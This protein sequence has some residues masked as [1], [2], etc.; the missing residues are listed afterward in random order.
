MQFLSSCR[1]PAMQ[2][3]LMLAALA[4]FSPGLAQAQSVVSGQVV[5]AANLRPLPG[6]QVAVQG[7]NRGTLTDGN[8]RFRV[9]V[10]QASVTLNVTF[11]G[12]RSETVSAT[13]G[14][15]V[16]VQLS[17]QAVALD[18]IVVTGT[19]GGTQRRALGHDVARVSATEIREVSPRVD[20]QGVL[21]GGSTGVYVSTSTGN[22][23]G[24]EQ[25]RLRGLSSISLNSV[26]LIYVD[27]VRVSN[28]RGGSTGSTRDVQ[29]SL[30]LNDISPDEIESI[31]VIKGPSAATLYGTEASA[32]VI[33]IITKRGSSGAPVF[34]AGVEY[35]ANY[36]RDPEGR[37]DWNYQINPTTRELTRWHPVLSDPNHAF[38]NGPI[39]NY[40]LGVGGGTDRIKYHLSG[41]GGSEEGYVDW[42][43][44]TRGNLR[45]NLDA[46]LSD[47]LN[48]AFS[49]GV[50]RSN[51][52]FPMPMLPYGYTGS[53]HWG[54]ALRT[55][56]DGHYTL[57]PSD[58]RKI[59][60]RS[61][62]ARSM[63]SL[64]LNH[65][66][67][68]WLR[69]RLTFGE[70]R[71]H[72]IADLLIERQPEGAQH[73][74]F[75]GLGLGQKT[76]E[77]EEGIY[78]SA[79]YSASASFDVTP[80]LAGSTS[81][82]FQH[83]RN[84][85][86]REYLFGREFAAPGLTVLDAASQS[87]ARG[88]FLESASVGMYVQQELSWQNRIFVTGAVRLDDNSA[89]GSEFDAAIY[90]KLSFSWVMHEEEWWRLNFLE[91]FRLRGAWGQAG[92]QPDL[93]AGVS[94]YDPVT[95]PGGSPAVRPG[96]V[97]NSTLGPEV[98]DE[99]EV[100]F[101]AGALND[102]LSVTFNF[103]N[104]RTIDALMLVPI[105]M[106]TGFTSNRWENIGE[107]SNRGIELQVNAGL[108]ESRSLNWDMGVS[109]T[110]NR[111]RLVDLGGVAPSS[112]TARLVEGEPIRVFYSAKPSG[113]EWVGHP[114]PAQGGRPANV[115]CE[116]A[117][118]TTEDCTA[119]Y[120]PSRHAVSYGKNSDPTYFGAVNSSLT[121]FNNL[122]LFAQANYEGGHINWGCRIGCSFGFFR[123]VQGITG[124]PN[125]GIAP[126]PQIYWAGQWLG[127]SDWPSNYDAT[128]VRLQTLSATYT[129]PSSITSRMGV[130]NA[131]LQVAGNN[132]ALWMKQTETGTR[133][134]V[135]PVASQLS[136][137]EGG[138]AGAFGFYPGSKIVTS[139]RLRF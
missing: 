102:R 110:T 89:F 58:E 94:L 8:G 77:V 125:N 14:T 132:L 55:A 104:Q 119:R 136:A 44:Q 107:V 12:Y 116:L 63:W 93:F 98:G 78:I 52:R 1:G 87:V 108:V 59:E 103:Y 34:E 127:V 29:P 5:D 80:S 54:H 83:Y 50:V 131:S 105:S 39:L 101:D 118:G 25:M 134:I 91:N 99:I 97:G 138:A 2:C 19:P 42:N 133:L 17:Q 90:P 73:P 38:Q 139:L 21:R 57:R 72:E 3:L 26:P 22:V 76:R 112:G 27:G 51:T 46:L 30:R 69:H 85:R 15:D 33:Q 123:L 41:S 74:A 49:S 7:S 71:T 43:T 13:V 120:I 32:G 31:E 62:L 111:N 60:N 20:V 4:V 67:R 40:N 48:L 47:N 92:R 81:A 109:L 37:L 70:D 121:L 129:L 35:G 18:A 84:S 117:D 61:R 135:E 86:E 56:N 6:A 122:R 137:S 114:D 106:A 82:G 79:E 88:T 11:I 75:G 130:S 124:D 113:G 128:H 45:G 36:Y 28:A 53:W 66:P 10:E 23:G 24:G 95:G 96:P 115:M 9:E 68:E 64:T 126:D 65:E 16:R 100:G